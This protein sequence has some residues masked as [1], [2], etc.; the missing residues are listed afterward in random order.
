MNDIL[1]NLPPD[2][3]IEKI[4]D[5]DANNKENENKYVNFWLL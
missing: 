1:K 2:G 4:L 5:I 3:K